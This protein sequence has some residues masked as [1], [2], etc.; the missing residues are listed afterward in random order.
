[1]TED[2]AKE[3]AARWLCFK[4]Y[5]DRVQLGRCI[6]TRRSFIFAMEPSQPGVFFGGAPIA[7][8]KVSKQ[9]SQPKGARMEFM[10]N[11]SLLDRFERWYT[12]LTSY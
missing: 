12:R 11:L 2:E 5:R 7:I 4:P 9:V 8:N 3:L 1:M 6:E 10:A